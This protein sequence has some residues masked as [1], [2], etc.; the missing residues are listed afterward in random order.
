MR[1]SI[2]AFANITRINF[3]RITIALWAKVEYAATY[4]AAQQ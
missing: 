1:I 4:I 2:K 3:R